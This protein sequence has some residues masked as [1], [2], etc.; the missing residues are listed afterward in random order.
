MLPKTLY[1][2]INR[3]TKDSRAFNFPRPLYLC[4]VILLKIRDADQYFTRDTFG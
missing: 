4:S 1:T 3:K 2:K